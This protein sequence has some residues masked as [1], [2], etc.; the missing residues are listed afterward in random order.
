MRTPSVLCT[1]G[2]AE[3]RRNK[4]QRTPGR[5]DKRW[6]IRGYALYPPMGVSQQLLTLGTGTRRRLAVFIQDGSFLDRRGEYRDEGV[7]G[8][9]SE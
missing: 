7:Q 4:T 9:A 5:V 1:L 6:G 8:V 2:K 3:E